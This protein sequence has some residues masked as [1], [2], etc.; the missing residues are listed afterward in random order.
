LNEAKDSARN[1]GFS[2]LA[3]LCLGQGL[4]KSRRRT[5]LAFHQNGLLASTSSFKAK[6][7]RK[8]FLGDSAGDARGQVSLF[9][10]P[11]VHQ[12]REKEHPHEA[13]RH[14]PHRFDDKTHH[15]RCGHDVGRG[16]QDRPVARLRCLN[17]FRSL[18]TSRLGVEK[19]D[20][21]TGK[22][23]LS[24]EDPQHAMT[25]QDLLRH[26][27]GLVYGPFG[28]LARST[29]LIT[30]PICSMVTRRWR[31]RDQVVEASRSLISLEQCGST[32]CSTDVVGAGSSKW[33]PECRSIGSSKTASPIPSACMT[34]VFYLSAV[35]AP[36][37]A[38]LQV[39]P[40]TG[41]RARRKQC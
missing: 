8:Q 12:D 36:R 6:S 27:S 7:I 30:R 32:A 23:A 25:V 2:L 38:E 20:P 5:M 29:K 26:T 22:P 34:P 10:G 39:D 28:Q 16:R 3:A 33:F 40:A 37:V 35:Q 14:L 41:K 9:P 15:E 19:I 4:P 21:S 24:L 1:L 31:V 13:R 17:I 11:S 18:R